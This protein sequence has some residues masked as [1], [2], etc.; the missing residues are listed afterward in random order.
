MHDGGIA[1]SGE[2]A[3]GFLQNAGFSPHSGTPAGAGQIAHHAIG[4]VDYWLG[5]RVR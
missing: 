2:R 1:V 4:R 3:I 5:E